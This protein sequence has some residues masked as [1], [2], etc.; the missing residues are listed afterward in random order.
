MMNSFEDAGKFGKEMMDNNLK[1]MAAATKG[2]QALAAEGA[3]F[4]KAQFET[5]SATLE[6][7]FSAKSLEKAMEIQ[8]DYLKNSYEAYVAQTTKVTDMI[9]DIAS[10]AYKP[11]EKAVAKVK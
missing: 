5:G 7:M 6:K 10:E 3:E 2:F 9:A 8:A 4:S 1:S 11:F